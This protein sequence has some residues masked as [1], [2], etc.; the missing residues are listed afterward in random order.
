VSEREIMRF[1]AA[2]RASALED[3]VPAQVVLQNFMFER[4]LARLTKTPIRE[5]LVIKGGLLVSSL[6]GL[7]RRTTMDLDASVRNAPLTED[8]LRQMLGRVFA[9][10]AHDGVVFRVTGVAPIRDD[11][12]YGGFR[13]K[14]TASLESIVVAL[15]AD[16]STGDVV[17]PEPVEYF[18][19]SRFDPNSTYRVWGYTVETI[20]AEKVQ[21]IFAR[22]VLNTRARDYY[23]IAMLSHVCKPDP[24]LF[25]TAF[26][27]TCSH[28]QTESLMAG[29]VARIEQLRTNRN[30]QDL[31]EKYRRQYSF[32]AEL[33]F[34]D[35]CR[36]VED[37]LDADVV[38]AKEI[39][40]HAENAEHAER[41]RR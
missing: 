9:K 34:D 40:S 1:K 18:L 29:S 41:S 28:R 33:S 20:L 35:V 4:F 39:A 6:L 32:A 38:S 5:N 19:K 17:T 22:G 30:L 12:V 8:R 2:I 27:A 14:F 10:D 36:A 11:D 25:V 16:F 7:S 15:S 3:G 13:V 23:D 37:L 24:A 26:R 31:W 21:T